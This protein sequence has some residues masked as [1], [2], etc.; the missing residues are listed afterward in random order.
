MGV[1]ANLNAVV[2]LAAEI[3]AVQAAVGSEDL[4][5][6]WSTIVDELAELKIKLTRLQVY[7]PSGTN[8]TTIGTALTALA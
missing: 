4:V 5:G 2:F 7:V 3:S 1:Y 6:E 8:L